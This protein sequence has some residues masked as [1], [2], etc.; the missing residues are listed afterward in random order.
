MRRG[1]LV[2]AAALCLWVAAAAEAQPRL[3]G[4]TETRY[5]QVPGAERGYDFYG[6]WNLDYAL[7]DWEAGVRV[8]AARAEE[9]YAHIQQRRLRYRRGAG[10]R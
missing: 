2:W 10:G 4:L 5:G 1:R 3:S 8:E 7:G 9:D 6:Q